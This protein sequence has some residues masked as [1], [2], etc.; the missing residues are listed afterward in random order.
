MGHIARDCRRRTVCKHCGLPG[1]ISE[2]CRKKGSNAARQF[3]RHVEPTSLGTQSNVGSLDIELSGQNAADFVNENDEELPQNEPNI[4]SINTPTKWQNETK[5]PTYAK[6]VENWAQYINGQGGKPK[7][8]RKAE[9]VISSG[10]NE[11][12]RDK[13][14]VTIKIENQDKNMLFDTG[15]DCNVIDFTFFKTLTKINPKLKILPKKHHLSCANGTRLSVIGYSLLTI[16][17]GAK[18]ATVK[19]TIVDKLFPNVIIGMNTMMRYN[20]SVSPGHKHICIG[21]SEI[22]PFISQKSRTLN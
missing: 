4:M 6:V 20:I 17:L 19:F 13:P 14:I 11:S 18:E 7:S 8:Y 16:S 1:H 15:C 3:I 5:R 12:A 2:N 9:T 21:K 10:A 22:L